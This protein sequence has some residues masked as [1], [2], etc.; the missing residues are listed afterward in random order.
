MASVLDIFNPQVTKSASTVTVTYCHLNFSG[1]CTYEEVT[2][3]GTTKR[4]KQRFYVMT[5]CMMDDVIE[6]LYQTGVITGPSDFHKIDHLIRDHSRTQV[7][8][9]DK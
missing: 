2:L 7:E 8:S 5:H 3:Q 1:T 9:K 4:F 6:Y